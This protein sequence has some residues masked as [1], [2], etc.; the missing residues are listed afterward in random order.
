V[1]IAEQSDDRSSPWS[2]SPPP[3]PSPELDTAITIPP[4]LRRARNSPAARAQAVVLD[5]EPSAGSSLQITAERPA[6]V[7][8]DD[9]A[10]TTQASLR[11][12][13]PGP[14]TLPGHVSAPFPRPPPSNPGPTLEQ[15]PWAAGLAARID[16]ALDDDFG[17]ET[18]VIPPT[19][20]EL[21]ALLGNPD[22]TRQAPIEEIEALR[23]AAGETPSEPD[24]LRPR[25]PTTQ[26]V[27]PDDIEAAIEL[28]PPAR[29]HAPNIIAVAKKK[30]PE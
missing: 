15:T 12:K 8:P 17:G 13:P 21:R 11:L 26:E 18:P 20:A 30:K 4:P 23:L 29:R 22:P 19:K 6:A 27:L 7:P 10:N 1:P 3:P 28:A 14:T 5:D 2:T 16:A 25:H 9:D 24:I